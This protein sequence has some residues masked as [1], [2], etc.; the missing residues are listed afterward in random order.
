MG[1]FLGCLLLRVDGHGQAEHILHGIDLF[2]VLRVPD[3][4]DGVQLRI[5]AMGRSA[6][7][8]IDLVGIR[9]R[10]Q[11]IR[12]LHPCLQQ[13]IHGC[14]VTG[15]RHDIILLLRLLQ[16]IGIGI[17]ERDIMALR[18]QQACQRRSHFSVAGNHNIHSDPRFSTFRF[19]IAPDSTKDNHFSCS[20][21]KNR[22][23]RRFEGG[24]LPCLERREVEKRVC[25]NERQRLT[26]SAALHDF[27]INR[28]YCGNIND[29]ETNCVRFFKKSLPFHQFFRYFLTYHKKLCILESR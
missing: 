25:T 9:C 6:G 4:G 1:N 10:N 20:S 12:F 21:A 26:A 23:A 11:Q 29:A 14:A 13:G 24:R 16:H 22:K 19:I 7:E 17:D 15:D 28:D 18:G 2:R 27:R 5:Q 8:Q 3:S